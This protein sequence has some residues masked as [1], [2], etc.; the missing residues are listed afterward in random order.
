VPTAYGSA[1]RFRYVNNAAYLQ[2]I[3][4]PWE[5]LSLTAGYRYDYSTIYGA[6]NTPRIGTVITPMKD[7]SIKLLASSGFRAPTAWELFNATNQRKANPDLKPERLRSYEFGVGYR[8]FRR[9]YVSVQQYYNRINNL[10]LEVQTAEPNPNQSGTNWNQNQNVGR[11]TIYGTEVET[12]VQISNSL[13]LF[14]NYTYNHGKY[15]DLSYSLT[16]S[17]STLWRHSWRSP[18]SRL[19]LI[20][21]SETLRIDCVHDD[22]SPLDRWEIVKITN[23]ID[24]V[25][26]RAHLAEELNMLLHRLCVQ[27]IEE[28]NVA[29]MSPPDDM[30]IHRCFDMGEILSHPTV[31]A[32]L[33]L[34][35]V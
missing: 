25:C 11:A 26:S 33:L 12:D 34:C 27:T 22:V 18:N 13:G 35:V 19:G 5:W 32:Q 6:A 16:S 28:E 23:L 20:Y 30:P 24:G 8:F 15:E 3:W 2:Q 1:R 14:L 4:G 31:F 21:R 9:Y 29:R 7:L 10:L 17:P